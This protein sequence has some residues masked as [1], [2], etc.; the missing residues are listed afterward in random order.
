VTDTRSGG[1]RIAV[2]PAQT[3]HLRTFPD[4]PPHPSAPVLMAARSYFVIHNPTAGR[5]RAGGAWARIEPIFRDAGVRYTAAA[6]ERPDHAEYLA[7]GAARQG[8]DVVVA[9][10]GDGTVQQTATGLMR[11]SADGVTIP[12]GIVGVGSGNDFIK[13]LDL[14]MQQPEAAAHRVLNG[15]TRRLDI[16]RINGRYFTNGVGIGFDAQ[17]AIEAS[18]VRH[19]RGM[20]LYGWALLKVLR[21]LR[22]PHIRLVLDGTVVA[23]RKATV[24][25][26]PPL[27]PSSP[28]RPPSRT[29][30]CGTSS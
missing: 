20:P 18:R 15:S 11:A 9:V 14:P 21:A 13:L 27:A 25:R 17:V 4:S 28:S 16:G 19:L 29:S 10:G 1:G 7:E 6:T 8:W 2:L 30:C 24:R 26:A 22:T 23:D 12:L 5:G 3:Y